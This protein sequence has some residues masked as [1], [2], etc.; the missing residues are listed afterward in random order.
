MQ[1]DA[2]NLRLAPRKLHVRRVREL[3]LDEVI[4]S[5]EARPRAGANYGDFQYM[6][7]ERSADFMTKG[8]MS[9]YLPED[10]KA[11]MPEGQLGPSREEW[12]QL[13]VLAHTDKARAC[14]ECAA[15]Y[16]QT[17]GQL[18]WSDDLQFSPSCP[19]PATPYTAS[20][21]GRRLPR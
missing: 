5:L 9:L 13:Y 18:Y 15:H 16:R 4:P 11:A 21:G 7:D 20:W 17:D 14:D 3:S 6:T 10:G 2:I 19:K 8:I 1:I 12:M